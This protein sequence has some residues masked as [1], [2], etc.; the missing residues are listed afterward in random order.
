MAFLLKRN[1]KT[2]AD[3]V[4]AL[5][6]LIGKWDF[7]VDS[8]K[9]Q[10]DCS[11]YLKQIKVILHGDEEQD[12]QPDQISALAQEVHATDLLGHLIH[13]LRKLDFDSRKDVLILFSTLLRRQIANE[14]PTAS[15]LLHHSEILVK[16]MKGPEYPDVALVCGQILRDCIKFESINRFVLYH[17]LFWRFFKYVQQPLFEVAT[18][19][20]VTLNALLTVHKKLV[21]EF[22][23]A[24]CAQFI[25][26]I[27]ELI[28]SDNYVTK[29]QSVRLLRELVQQK[30]NQQFLM[31][32][33]DDAKSLKIV[34]ILLSDKSKNVQVEGF[35]IFKFF[36]AK[37]KKSPKIIDIL[38]KN[39]DNFQHFFDNFDVNNTA[40]GSVEERDYI[41][42]EIQKLEAPH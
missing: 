2:P 31:S 42:Q 21:A 27:N 38:A 23:S 5:N 9:Y 36:V 29:R 8:K 17:P 33:F 20:F 28:K 41:L 1:P 25:E 7:N 12:P 4:R 18:D 22:L 10:D 35:H 37:P 34:M 13:N 30:S 15:Y 19:V 6:E 32:Y 16:L 11:R 26:H 3:L 40:P 39:K 14:S 24:N